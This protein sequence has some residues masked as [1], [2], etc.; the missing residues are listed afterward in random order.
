MQGSDLDMHK[1]R[2]I[3]ALAENQAVDVSAQGEVFRYTGTT[4]TKHEGYLNREDAFVL[5]YVDEPI[6]GKAFRAKVSSIIGVPFTV[7][8]VYGVH[9]AD[10][11]GNV[12]TIAGK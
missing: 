12:T 6:I 2:G 7:S 4:D 10:K 3:F 11:D 9:L 5:E 1:I 8:P